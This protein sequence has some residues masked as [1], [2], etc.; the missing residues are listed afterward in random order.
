MLRN[1]SS[2]EKGCEAK[3]EGIRSSNNN[4]DGK[5]SFSK[6]AS[7]SS[8]QW[9]GFRNPRIVRVS[10]SFGGKDRHSKVCTIRGLRDRRIRLSVPTAIQLYDLQDKLKLGQ[11][12]KV[13]DWLLDVTKLDIDNLPPLQIPPGFS[14]FHQ[15]ML[16]PQYDPH[17]H[18]Y[19]TS[20]S[21]SRLC[22]SLPPPPPP[23]SFAL[24]VKGIDAYQTTM[25]VEK[26]KLWDVDLGLQEKAAAATTATT[27]GKWIDGSNTTNSQQVEDYNEQISS[28]KLL[29][30][31]ICSSNLPNMMNNNSTPYN[32]YNSCLSLSQFGN[33]NNDDNGNFPSQLVEA[34]AQTST[35]SSSNSS[36]FFTPYASYITN[37]FES[38]IHFLS[39]NSH[40]NLSNPFMPNSSLHPFASQNLKPFPPP[41]FNLKQLLHAADNNPGGSRAGASSSAKDG[42]AENS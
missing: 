17:H 7:T 2:K 5:Y 41:S 31:A 32:N 24:D 28:Q 14:P 42:A 20:S 10:R 1:N 25:T 26:T 19:S 9:S 16:F 27:K 29:S 34:A 8:R 39:S 21:S 33:N 23:P 13:I 4:D 11:P 22:N 36:L 38:H 6:A 40:V 18:Y 30:M 35:S 3:E 12:S 37:P 15:Q